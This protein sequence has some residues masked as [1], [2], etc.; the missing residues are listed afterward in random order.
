VFKCDASQA[1]RV[2]RI[3]WVI[4]ILIVI[5][6]SVL[7]S[8]SA[9]MRALDKLGINDKVEHVTAYLVLALLPSI[10]ERA[11][12]VVG[13]AIGAVLLGIALE[14]VQLYSGWRDFEVADMVADAVGVCLGVAFGVA[15]RS[16]SLTRQVFSD[17]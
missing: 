15:V 9:P 14:Y 8:F 17:R 16:L 5:I 1:H 11:G 6:G 13:A 2:L 10:H 7:P 12:M 4:A 3:L